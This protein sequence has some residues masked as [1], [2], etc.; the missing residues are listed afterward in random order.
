MPRRQTAEGAESGIRRRGGRFFTCSGNTCAAA[1]Q[2][3]DADGAST[4]RDAR[5]GAR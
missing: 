1:F 2:S 5:T 3:R 4:T